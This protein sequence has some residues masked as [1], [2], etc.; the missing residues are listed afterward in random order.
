MWRR[1]RSPTHCTSFSGQLSPT[2]LAPGVQVAF[3]VAAIAGAVCTT[4][5]NVLNRTTLAAEHTTA[6][7]LAHC[8]HP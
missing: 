4:V 5:L 6:D 7:A 1:M 8:I 2:L 3:H